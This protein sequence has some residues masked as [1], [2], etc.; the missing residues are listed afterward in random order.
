MSTPTNSS[1]SG[2][3]KPPSF[4]EP[5][6]DYKDVKSEGQPPSDTETVTQPPPPPDGGIVAWSQVVGAFFL[7]FSSW[8]IVNT[9]GAFQTYYAESL[10][11]SYSPS[12]ISWIGTVQGFLLFLLG[13]V[14]GPAY[15]KGYL[16]AL[17]GFGLFAV[18]FGLMMTSLATEY[19]QLFLAHGICVGIGCA[20]LFVPS[21]AIV[22]T[23]FTTKRAVATGITA[24]G[25]SIGSVIFPIIFRRL[26]PRIGFGWTTRIIAFIVLSVLLV[27]LSV[28][29]T[30]LP[31]PKH[32]RS[33]FDASA[34]K[35]PPFIVFSAG[36]FFSFVGL[37]FPFFYLPTYLST[38][39]NSS[40]NISL[41]SLAILNAAS[42]FGRVTPGLVADRI[43][44]LNTLIPMAMGATILAFA[45]I[46][47]HNIAGT[48]VFAVLFGFVSGAIVSLPPTVVVRMTPDVSV[49]GTRMGMCF[50]FA[51]FGLLIGNPIAGSLLN[52]ERDLF[53]HAQIF[54][55]TLLAAGC[56]CFIILWPLI[57][58]PSRRQWKV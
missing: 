48:I 30:R 51:G 5:A 54:S 15:D 34:F 23:Y 18:V 36:L 50:T 33:L 24:S 56:I 19:Y 26:V 38:H 3:L 28:M 25:G 13:V 47:I 21:V 22:S 9:F 44:S 53:W 42:V 35:E 43:G 12:A 7:F 40:Q 10:I 14:A 58:K 32:S 6:P 46:G 29:K 2:V 17:I 57:K 55:A 41:Y 4:R 37:Y 1:S 45:W 39:L 31:P 49:I 20:C 11:P 16:H 52:L 8:G 27:S